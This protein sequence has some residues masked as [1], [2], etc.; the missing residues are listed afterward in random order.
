MFKC[1]HFVVPILTFELH[2]C[3][4]VEILDVI[5]VLG[6]ALENAELHIN[7]AFGAYIRELVQR[8]SAL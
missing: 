4:N 5:F 2:L 1:E 3:A 8:N 6:H 7:E